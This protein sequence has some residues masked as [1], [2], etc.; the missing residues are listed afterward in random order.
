MRLE[1]IKMFES[2]FQK[3]Y[4]AKNESEVEQLLE[5]GRPPLEGLEWSHLGQIE[6]NFGVIENQQSNPVAAIVEKLTNSIDAI[7]MRRCYEES[8]DP[9]GPAAPRSVEEAITRFFPKHK[10]WDQSSVRNQQAAS[11]QI[12]GDSHPGNTSDTSLIIY[13]DGE[14]QHPENFEDTLLSLLQGNKNEIHFVQGKYNMGGSGAIVFCGEKR[15]QLIASKRYDGS[16]LFGFTLIRKHP[17]TDEEASIKR[18]TWYEYLKVD[19]E[20]PAFPIDKL[21]LGLYKRPFRTG[22]IIKLYSYELTGNRHVRRDLGRS[23]NEFLYAPALPIYTVETKERYPKDSG[24]TS[25]IFGLKQRLQNND[26]VEETFSETYTDRQIGRM[27]VTVHLFRARAKE[28]T[29]KETRQTIRDEF[30]KNNMAVLFSVNGQVHG[31]YTTEFITRSLGF[32]MLKDYLLIHV[33]CTEMNLDFRNELF[34]ASRDRLKQGKE[35][36][37]LRDVL[38]KNL[39]KGQLREI[40]KRRK[41]TISVEAED[42]EDLLRSIAENMPINNELRSLLSQTFKLDR[43]DKPKKRRRP[44]PGPR[45]KEEFHPKRF[46]SFFNLDVNAENGRPVITIPANESKTIKF[47]TDVENQYFDRTEEPGD[48]KI[49]LMGYTSNGSSGGNTKGTVNDIHDVLTVNRSSPNE[50]SIRVVLEPTEDVEVG[51]EIEIQADLSNPGNDLTERFWVK[52]NKPLPKK[53]HEVPKPEDEKIGLPKHVLVYEQKVP[54]EPNRKLWE[55]LEEQGITM[56][57]KVV[58]YPRVESDV[59]E[60]IY[61]NMDSNVLKNYKSEIHKLSTEQNQVANKRYISSVYYHTLFLYVINRQSGYEIY[62]RLA[63]QHDQPQEVDL[64]KYLQDIF[65]SH[66]AEFLM[67]FGVDKLLDSLGE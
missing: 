18:N 11:I 16:G 44:N 51:D 4:R 19:G 39:K 43:E 40:Y 55:N 23:L 21:D 52:I 57:R 38:A 42:D 67:N 33:D 3:L 50:G 14:G 30:F 10:N 34:M 12:I 32:N 28:K 47:N 41:D 8:I 17:L 62:Q 54:E 24:L 63:D 13:D 9:K 61:I 45:P 1:P 29:A 58:M 25:A 6:S 64:S 7:L 59:L 5:E 49:A 26:Y 20:I 53:K 22:T 2:L 35:S 31:H 36:K 15:Y 60:T 66:Y 37:Q 48:M 65:S 27:N 46:P 56:D